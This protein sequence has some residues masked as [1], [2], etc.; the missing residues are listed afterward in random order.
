MYYHRKGD[1]DA[2]F[3]DYSKA[4]EIDPKTVDAYINRGIVCRQRSDYE[5]AI[6]DYSKAINLDPKYADAYYN[7]A[8]SY[9]HKKHYDKAW[10]DV[11]QAQS[12]GYQVH[13]GFL[14]ALREASRRQK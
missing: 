10:K 14:Q 5:A 3:K 1:Y 4:I 13:P 2:A 11:D 8:V 7:R 9:F 6:R 12:L